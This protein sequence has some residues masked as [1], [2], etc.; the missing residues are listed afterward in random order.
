MIKAN[1]IIDKNIWKKNIQSPK[2]YFKKKLK[3]ISNIKFFKKKNHYLTILLTTD[4]VMKKLNNKFRKKNKTTD[5]LSF[6]FQDTIKKN[7]YLGDIAISYEI[8]RKRSENSNFIKE[9]DK[10][11][12]HGLLHLLGYNHKNIKDYLRMISKES[13]ILTNLNK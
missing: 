5:V 7:S 10:M 6:P 1:I 8:V 11:W 12:I 9:L 2:K 4:K 13:L 3:I